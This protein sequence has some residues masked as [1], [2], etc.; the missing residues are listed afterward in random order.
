MIDGDSLHVNK[1]ITP[2]YRLPLSKLRAGPGRAGGQWEGTGDANTSS[3][4]ES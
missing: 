4:V 3:E 2:I 1:Y